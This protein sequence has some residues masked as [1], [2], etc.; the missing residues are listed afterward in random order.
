VTI[1]QSLRLPRVRP[2]AD[3]ALALGVLLAV[4]A[5]AAVGA[6][7]LVVGLVWL[8][9]VTP[10]LVAVDIAEHRLPDAIVLP[11]LAVAGVSVLV[12]GRDLPTAI[13]AAAG[14]GILLLLLHVL[15]G[16]GLGDVKLA[17][18]L[19]LLTGALG[20]LA[21][22]TSPLLAFVAGGAA[23]VAVLI[24]RGPGAAMPFGPAMLLGAW[25]AVLLAR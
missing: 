19:G 22:V 7:P 3:T 16:M 8:A 2:R 9:L 10:R 14:Y 6:R 25:A 18:V 23:A 5:V 13:A 20:S 1:A 17:P 4:A 21:A 15:G 12:D 24:R 11:A